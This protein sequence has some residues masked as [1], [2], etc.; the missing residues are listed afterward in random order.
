MGDDRLE[1]VSATTDST[2]TCENQQT[3]GGAKSGAVGA[4][5]GLTALARRLLELPEEDRR[6]LLKLLESDDRG[7]EG[8]R[9][10]RRI[11]ISS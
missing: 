8:A 10:A 9:G 3:D 11:P 6:R 7:N 1:L 2:T 4:E 5:N